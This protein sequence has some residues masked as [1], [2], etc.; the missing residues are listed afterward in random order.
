M[1]K[2]FVTAGIGAGFGGAFVMVMHVASTA[3]SPSGILGTS[4]MLPEFMLL[5]VIGLVI[6]YVM[7]AIITYAFIPIED[8]KAA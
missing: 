6:S 3:F 4:I 1:M 7:G 2:P 8:V 5:Y